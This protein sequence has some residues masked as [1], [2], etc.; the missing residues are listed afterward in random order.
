[1]PVPRLAVLFLAL[2]AAAAPALADSQGGTASRQGRMLETTIRHVLESKGFRAVSHAEW[3]RGADAFGAEL[4]LLNVPFTSIYGGS[5]RTEFVLVSKR[6]G[7]RVRIEAK[8]QQVSGS[9]DTKLPYLY[10][11]AVEAMPEDHVI[12][13]IGGDGWR[14]GA[15]AWLRRAASTKAYTTEKSRAKRVDVMSLAEFLA[16]ANAAFR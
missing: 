5:G 4:L 6:Y 10:L 16:W 13:V 15:V 7:V 8:W 3:K 11:N 12:F 1:M 9:T 2:A 14:P